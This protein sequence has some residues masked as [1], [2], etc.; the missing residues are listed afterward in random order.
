MQL[1]S[2]N[3]TIIISNEEIKQVTENKEGYKY[4]D[5]LDL[6]METRLEIYNGFLKTEHWLEYDEE[7][8]LEAPLSIFVIEIS[9]Q[10]YWYITMCPL[11]SDEIHELEDMLLQPRYSRFFLEVRI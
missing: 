4:I 1:I 11:T 2:N 7:E 3:N 5:F 8:W 6:S 9:G 10:E